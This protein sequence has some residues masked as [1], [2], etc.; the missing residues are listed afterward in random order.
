MKLDE[1]RF[2]SKH[3][4]EFL[5]QEDNYNHTWNRPLY[6]LFRID[7]EHE[8]NEVTRTKWHYVNRIY[9][10]RL[11]SYFGKNRNNDYKSI[12]DYI[13]RSV[14]NRGDILQCVKSL[15]NINYID[16]NTLKKAIKS[17]EVFRD[18]LKEDF[19][20]KTGVGPTSFSSKYLH[21]HSG[22]VPIYDKNARVSVCWVIEDYRERINAKQDDAKLSYKEYADAVFFLL[23]SYFGGVLFL[24]QQMKNLDGYLH[25]LYEGRVQWP[26]S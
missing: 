12:D 1:S 10:T 25:A 4:R 17:V 18:T 16:E 9:S 26:T 11:A 22:I 7:S 3:F 6:D 8:N 24:P 21:F 23:Q 20:T 14:F 13:E 2:S 15:N 19:K 5:N